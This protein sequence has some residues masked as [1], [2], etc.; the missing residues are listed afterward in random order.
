MRMTGLRAAI[1]SAIVGLAAASP[2]SAWWPGYGYGWYG[3][4][5]PYYGYTTWGGY[6]P[7]YSYYY[8][9]YGYAYPY[10]SY[11]S[12]YNPYYAYS[13]YYPDY[14]YYNP[15]YYVPQTVAALPTTSAYQRFYPPDTA[16][17]SP[18][19]AVIRVYTAP[20]A[21]L[22]F[23]GTL[24]AQTGSLRTFETPD[25]QPGKEFKY[26]IKVRW[27]ENGILIER[28]RTVTVGAGRTVNLD[29][30]PSALK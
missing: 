18:N 24:T 28:K 11:S 30:A 6:Y 9:T 25:L 22:W 7:G 2:A 19:E 13:A 5:W 1:F 26:D 12:S 29:L 16:L 4:Y 21:Q 17:T 10:Y 23:D 15:T 8:P 3:G 20:D 27:V 14:T